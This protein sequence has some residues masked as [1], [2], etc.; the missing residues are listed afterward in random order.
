M[1]K[2]EFVAALRKSPPWKEDR[3]GHFQLEWKQTIKYRLKVQPLSV[4]YERKYV[5]YGL[6]WNR[7]SDYYKN[8][9]IDGGF[10][11]IQ[12]RKIP[13]EVLPE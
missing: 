10:L 4:R 9:R 7:A 1:T 5:G 6:W 2:T 8:V 12:G 13:L 11:V 3:F